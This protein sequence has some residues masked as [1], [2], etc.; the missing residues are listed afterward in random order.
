MLNIINRNIVNNN[1]KLRWFND[2]RLMYVVYIFQK[3]LMFYVSIVVYV[4]KVGEYI[5]YY[6]LWEDFQVIDFLI[7]CY[8]K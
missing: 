7:F 4:G 6:G 5:S 2:K 8:F 1:I 3:F